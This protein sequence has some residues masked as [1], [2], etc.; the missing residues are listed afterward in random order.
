MT[1][2]DV[3]VGAYLFGLTGFGMCVFATRP[4][5]HRYRTWRHKL[6]LAAS[7]VTWPLMVLLVACIAA[8]RE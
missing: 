3:L 7:V 1:L 4:R 8:R 6:L 2:L 5:D